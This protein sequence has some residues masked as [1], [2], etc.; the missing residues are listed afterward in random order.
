MIRDFPEKSKT[1]KLR[2]DN[3]D[4]IMDDLGFGSAI[5]DTTPK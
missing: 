1:I 5:S 2:E 3:I 4:K